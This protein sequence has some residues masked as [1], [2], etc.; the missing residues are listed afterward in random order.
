MF[1]DFGHDKGNAVND[2][3]WELQMLIS[4]ATEDS[5]KYK[6]QICHTLK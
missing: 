5:A 3:K 6:K 2:F 4:E 1:G